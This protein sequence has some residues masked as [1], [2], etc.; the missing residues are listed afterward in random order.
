ML[1]IVEDFVQHRL[2]T[3]DVIRDVL[4]VSGAADPGREI[5][6]RDLDADAMAALELVR[7]RQDLDRV[8]VDLAG[9]DRLLHLARKRMPRPAGQPTAWGR[10]RDA[11]P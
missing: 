1:G 6:T 3:A 9:L 8:F 7:G 10:A 4:D 5:E 11:R 2:A